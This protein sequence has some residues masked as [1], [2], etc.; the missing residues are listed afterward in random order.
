[1]IQTNHKVR[2]WCCNAL[3]KVVS[4]SMKAFCVKRNQGVRSPCL[5]PTLWSRTQFHKTLH[6][7]STKCSL[8]LLASCANI[9]E[10]V[11]VMSEDRLLVKTRM[12][13][14]AVITACVSPF[15]CANDFLLHWRSITTTL[16]QG[17]QR[18]KNSNAWL[19]Q[20]TGVLSLRGKT[21]KLE[22][23]GVRSHVIR[24][25]L[26][27]HSPMSLRGCSY[28]DKAEFFAALLTNSTFDYAFLDLDFIVEDLKATLQ[29][30][31]KV[32]CLFWN[33]SYLKKLPV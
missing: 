24:S 22:I 25:D 3:L 2:V 23:Q 30:H 19:T 10:N 8:H 14:S 18:N 11:Q 21:Q 29:T 33:W 12:V 16:F 17:S 20:E 32:C 27:Q 15:T 31:N 4:R 26:W 9:Q 13:L 6:I 1:M 7:L 28:K 5:N